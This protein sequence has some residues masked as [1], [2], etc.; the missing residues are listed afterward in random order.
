MPKIIIA[1]QEIEVDAP[2]VNYRQNGWDATAERCLPLPN[3]RSPA[4]TAC[5][6]P[7]SEKAK[8]RGARRYGYRP[9][10]RRYGAA[11]PLAAAQAAIKQFVIHFDGMYS[12]EGCFHVLQNERGLSCH[13]LLDNDGTIYQTLDLAYA[14]FHASE[15]NPISIGVE[16]CNRGDAKKWP[17]YYDNKAK[18]PH[19]RE[20]RPCQVH[21]Y[22]M[23]GWDYTQPQYDSLRRLARALTKILPNLPVEYPQKA[24][25]VQSWEL[26]APNAWSYAGYVGHYHLTTRKWDPGPFDFKAFCE[27]MRG[28]KC[29]P[30]W[31]GR[32]ETAVTDKPEI[33]EDLDELIERTSQLYDRNEQDAEG[34]YFPVGP[35]GDARL[36]HGGVHLVGD[37]K[38]PLFA[39]FP[40]RVVLARMGRQS[41][42]GSMNFVL[43]RHDMSVGASHIRFFTLFMHLH[44]ELGEAEPAPKWMS[45]DRWLKDKKPGQ[46]IP[47]DVPVAAGDVIGRIGRVGPMI[48]NDDLSKA[49][50]HFAVFSKNELFH[51]FDNN[52]WRVVDGS[53]SGRFCDLRE[54]N[55]AIDTDPKDG[56]L[57]R[58]ELVS[59]FST[60]G[61][62]Q[63]ARY[64]A[65]FCLSEW[66]DS[67]PWRDSLKLQ[68]EYEQIDD[69]TLDAMIEEQITPGLWWTRD[70]AIHAG[71]P[72]E[73]LVVHYHPVTF[74]RFINEKILESLADPA[75]QIVPIDPS[76]TEV[77]VLLTDAGEDS[78]DAGGNDMV[79][80]ADLDPMAG[81]ELIELQHLVEGYAGEVLE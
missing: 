77:S 35:W 33:P 72:I 4:E 36:W 30:M 56:R 63:A 27:S 42:I 74:V 24:P 28:A 16:M 54:I 11:P 38:Q 21:G 37:A 6:T 57:S 40:G 41:P 50:V 65:V 51:E 9:M 66:T 80:D 34:G 32:K 39:P 61:D 23:L 70:H 60:A 8:N 76:Q 64:L 78:E 75:N 81:N 47:L 15:Y 49:Q 25:G 22:K 73:G 10:L 68:A 58:R 20:P 13:F 71:L 79:T 52:P 3:F 18:F 5:I 46:V 12:S 1:N 44:D 45:D 59:F 43:L 55:D 26:L 14:G 7:F 31:S 62:R 17:T 2:V 53:G 67:P 19:A 69:A 29:F 48:E